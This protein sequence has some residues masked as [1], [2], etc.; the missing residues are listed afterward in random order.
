MK[1]SIYLVRTFW[2]VFPGILL[3]ASS[4]SAAPPRIGYIYPGGG[5]AGSTFEVEFGGQYLSGPDGAIVSGEGISVEII[6]HN[7]LPAAQMISDFR[8]RLS[9]IRPGLKSLK[10]GRMVP[11][12]DILPD[13]HRLLAS[14]ELDE[15]KIRQIEEYTRERND[16]KRQLN[17]QI[18]E[19]VRARISIAANATPG[20]RYCRLQTE[21]GL[22]NPMRFVVGSHPEMREPNPWPFRL[23]DYLGIET[24]PEVETDESVIRGTLSL[25]VTINGRILP[26]EVDEFVFEAR[27]GDQVVV[28]VDARNLIPYLADAVPGWFQAVVSLV[29]P[30][31]R[32]LAFSDDYRFNPDPVLFYKI[33]RDGKF[34]LKIH[35]SIY[36]GRE[37]FVYR[38]TLGELPFLTGLTPLGGQAGAEVDLAFQGGNLTEF[39][40]K[41]FPLPPE[42]GII[43]LA[44]EGEGGFSNQISFHVDNVR[45]DAEREDND[46]MGAANGLELPCVMNGAI[47]KP[48]DVDYYRAKGT[49]NQPM[50]FEIFARRLGSPLDSNLTIFDDDGKQIAWND[51]FENPSAGL[52]THHADARVTVDLPS[53]GVCFVRVA[54]TQNQSGYEFTYRLKV[55][56]GPPDIALR[57]TPSSVNAKPGGTASL[58]VHAL[59]LDGYEGA[60][61]LELVDPPEGYV[62]KTAAIPAGEESVRVS[63]SVPSSITEEPQE[64]QLR[65]RVFME[66]KEVSS[67]EVVPAEDMTQAFITKHIV[68]VDAVLIDIRNPPVKE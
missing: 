21:N 58:A 47:S 39:E 3:A 24:R 16:P 63:I 40:R 12:D 60:I 66:G 13:I 7:R 31:G 61:Q 65:G 48:G 27:E 26:G 49:G 46:R 19:T 8:D 20:M 29:D 37:D 36:R 59:R 68:P 11:A 4:L 18:G 57:A 5:Q 23:T 50:T 41:R 44:A 6:E 55:S 51:D 32:E 45:E 43:Q 25:P 64:I 54:E 17:S 35:D 28:S 15:K 1:V 10:Q 2:K 62:L 30:R 67:Y 33:P 38:I 42:P 14:V 52:T 9:T 34:R 53:N 22:S 56:Q